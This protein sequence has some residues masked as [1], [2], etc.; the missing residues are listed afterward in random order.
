[1]DERQ[2]KILQ[3][4]QTHCIDG[5]ELDPADIIKLSGSLTMMEVLEA[6]P[7]LEHEGYIEVIEIDMC[8]GADYIVTGIT[9]KGSSFLKSF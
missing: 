4:A 5:K 9:E 6:I 3:L 2:K 8:C 7:I 1:M